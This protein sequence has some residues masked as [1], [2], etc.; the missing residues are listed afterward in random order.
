MI[1][2]QPCQNSLQGHRRVRALPFSAMDPA[3][4]PP[5]GVPV[6]QLRSVATAFLAMRPRIV[7]PAAMALVTILALSPVPRRQVVAVGIG[8]SALLAFFGW[9]ALRARRARFDEVHL[10]RSLLVTLGMLGVACAATGG[11]RSPLIP[12][13][14]A[15]TVVALSAFGRA[16]PSTVAVLSFLAIVVALTLLPR[17]VPFPPVPSPWDVPMAFVALLATV[18]LLR[19]GVAGLSDAYG[20]AAVDLDVARDAVM[21]SAEARAHALESIGAKVAHEVKN[22]L[23]AVRGLMELVRAGEEGPNAKRL[24][25]ALAEVARI[26]AIL[27]DYLSY[28]RPLSELRPTSVALRPLCEAVRSVMEARAERAFVRLEVEGDATVDA[29]PDRLKEALMNVVGNALEA[30]SS[31]GRIVLSIAEGPDGVALVVRDEGRGMSRAALA[32]LGTPGFTTRD[33]GTGLGVVLARGAIAQHGGTLTFESEPDRGTR[34][35]ITLP[36]R[37]GGDA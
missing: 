16:R 29:D 7:A 3:R 33:A 14:F 28:S 15:P 35:T 1:H 20:R 19:V 34:A 26:E 11:V 12:L 10:F 17:G 21:A 2:R 9:E 5:L 36:R 30:S 8:T 32:R 13:L 27:R 25:V 4:A 31:G 18:L 6:A 37:I 24:D 23:S 22:P